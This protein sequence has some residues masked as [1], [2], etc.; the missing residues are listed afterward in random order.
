M[1]PLQGRC[2]DPVVGKVCFSLSKYCLLAQTALTHYYRK[3]FYD[4]LAGP[5]L[6]GCSS[7]RCTAR[8]WWLLC[9]AC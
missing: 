2:A 1:D 6:V 4:T 5:G 3:A 8:S 9:A 7:V